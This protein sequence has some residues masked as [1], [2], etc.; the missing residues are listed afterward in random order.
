M[1]R[2]LVL[3]ISVLIFSSCSDPRH[4]FE[5]RSNRSATLKDESGFPKKDSGL[6]KITPLDEPTPFPSITPG[7]RPAT[8]GATA[9]S[10]DIAGADGKQKFYRFLEKNE[11]KTIKLDLLL[12]D[13]QVQQIND[14]DRGKTWYFDLGFSDKDSFPTGGE[15][16][17]DVAKS[18]GD[19]K[20]N[21][22]HLTGNI[23]V[24]D[25]S[26]PRQGLMSITAK[27]A[28]QTIGIA[29]P[30]IR[31]PEPFITSTPRPNATTRPRIVKPE[32]KTSN[33]NPPI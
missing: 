3:S 24:L 27:P 14:V 20:L 13:D 11:Q 8:I 26:G 6:I 15:L 21:G 33:N 28:T 31:N 9:F 18:K 4:Y 19:L 12:S 17:I 2:I 22:N 7:V 29:P 25:W 32:I 30:I 16:L 23:K 10:G 5:D 1:S